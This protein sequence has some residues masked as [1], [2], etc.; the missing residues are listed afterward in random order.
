MDI[1]LCKNQWLVIGPHYFIARNQYMDFYAG[2][3]EQADMDGYGFDLYHKLLLSNKETVN[4]P[5]FAYGVRYDHFT[6]KY[7]AYDW[8]KKTDGWGTPYYDWEKTEIVEK[9]NRYGFNLMFGLQ[10]A[11]NNKLFLDGYTGCG[12][13]VSN[14]SP[15]DA[16]IAQNNNF[17]LR[18]SYSGPRFLLG[19]RLG[20]FLF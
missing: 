15:E 5:Y 11:I 8:V 17:F 20:L 10:Y 19:F 4:G 13:Q 6:F 1:H 3:S 18:Y 12:I 2:L 14:I 7:K 16:E 9:N